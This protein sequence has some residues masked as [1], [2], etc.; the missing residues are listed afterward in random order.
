MKLIMLASNDEELRY[1]EELKADTILLSVR[2]IGHSI[3]EHLRAL[4]AK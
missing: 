2:E 4:P 1:Y 3:A